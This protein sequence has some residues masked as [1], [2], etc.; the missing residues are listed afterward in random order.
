MSTTAPAPATSPRLSS[1]VVLDRA[2]AAMGAKRRVE[3]EV[4]ESALAWAEAHVV[5]DEEVAAGWRSDTVHTPGSAAALFGERPLPIAGDGTPLVAEFAVIELAGL[6]E[7]S[8]EATLALLGD[9]LD[10]AHR[11]PRLW[12]LVRSLAVPVRLAREAARVSRDLDVV[13]AGH[14]DRLLVW[15]PRRLNPHRVGVLVHEARLYADPDRAIADHDE[16]LAARRVEVHHEQGAPGVSEVFMS[17]DTADAIAFDNTVSTMATTMKA[18]G[19]HGDLGVRRAHAVGLLAD[20]QQALDLLAAA[21]VADP[22]REVDPDRD[23]AVCV[24]EEAT[25]A[26]ADPFRRP[27]RESGTAG[28]NGEVRLVLHL[29]DRDLL[30]DPHGIDPRG[31]ARSDQLGPMLLGRLQAWLL[32]AAKVVIQPVTDA[33][34]M[35]AVDAHDPPARMAAAVR[36][37]DGTCVFP[38]CTR[39]SERADL[40]HITAYVPIDDGGPPGQTHPVNLAPLCRRHHRAKTFGAFTYHRRPDGAYEWTLPTGRRITTDPPRPRPRPEPTSRP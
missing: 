16:A 28:R 3:V 30:T 6:L 36:L 21:D 24:A 22:D 14:A 7:Q 25:Y 19:H 20:P 27:T 2:V 26:S 12:V 1:R 15:Q 33:D 40:D 13:A 5:S 9:V 32:T 31:V 39:P 35:P 23:E 37:R 17:L 29:T 38:G 34:R 4:L 11:L 10:L 18:L 8:H